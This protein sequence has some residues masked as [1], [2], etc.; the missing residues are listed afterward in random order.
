MRDDG[1]EGVRDDEK[2]ELRNDEKPGVQD[3]EKAEV[4]NNERL[5]VQDNEK[6]EVRDKEG[7]D[8]EAEVENNA[9]EGTDEQEEEVRDTTAMRGGGKRDTD[10]PTTPLGGNAE[11]NDD[12]GGVGHPTMS[13]VMQSSRASCPFIYLLNY[14]VCI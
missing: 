3:D 4:R 2:A 11:H 9:E 8:E 13:R 7:E 10:T 14:I 1:K 5:G 6:P 12:N